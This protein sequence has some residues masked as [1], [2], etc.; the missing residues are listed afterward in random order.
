[1][2]SRVA[3]NVQWFS[4]RRRKGK[5]AAG[6]NIIAIRCAELQR[7]FIARYGRQ[8]PD[9]D[10]GRDDAGLMAHHLAHRPGDARHRIAAWLASAAPWMQG[11]ERAELLAAVTAKPRRWKADTLAAR[12]G[13]T[14]AERERLQI[15]TIGAIDLDKAE[16]TKRRRA[17]KTA[18]DHERRR[19]NGAMSRAEYEAGSTTARQPWSAAGI[20][21]RTWYRRQRGTG[22]RP[23]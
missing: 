20:S 15:T 6:F 16:R 14:E 3:V 1:M 7:L 9:D 22:V 23:A 2:E 13:L 18:A 12:V 21:R 17:R 11:P 4:D 8:L 5:R 19:A 10:A